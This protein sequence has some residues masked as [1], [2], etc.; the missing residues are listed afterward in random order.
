MIG[1]NSCL[2]GLNVLDYNPFKDGK[3]HHSALQYNLV[4]IL[5]NELAT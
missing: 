2:F 1:R 4:E 3:W 5:N